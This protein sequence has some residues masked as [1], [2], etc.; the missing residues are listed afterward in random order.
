VAKGALILRVNYRGSAGYGE[1]FR[2]LNV[3]DLGIGDYRDVIAGVDH[4]IAQ[5]MVDR[6]R[7][8]AMGWSQG[9]PVKMIV[10]K[11]FGHGIYKPKQTLAMNQ[12]N[13]DWFCQ[14]IWGE[15]P[16]GR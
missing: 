4:L 9:V 11:G 7:V 12:A 13:Y 8:G 3:R 14:W 1:K 16:A 15:K 10:Y 6:D 5:G 2:A